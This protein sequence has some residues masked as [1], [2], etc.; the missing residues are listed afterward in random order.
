MSAFCDHLGIDG[1]STA[2]ETYPCV[3]DPGIAVTLYEL[4]RGRAPLPS[5]LAAFHDLFTERLKAATWNLD[6]LVDLQR[7]NAATRECY[8]FGGS[9][10][11]I[12]AWACDAKG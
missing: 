9:E 4:H 8:K 10:C 11:V 3:T 12:R 5:E 2:W 6:K 1:I 7:L